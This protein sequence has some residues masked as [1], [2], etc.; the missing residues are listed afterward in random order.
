MRRGPRWDEHVSD[1][2]EAYERLVAEPEEDAMG[3]KIRCKFKCVSVTKREGWGSNPI[4][5]DAAF[6]VV[7]G[8]SPENNS[9][10]AATP[11][12]EIKV[13]TVAADRFE[14]GK[15]YFVDFSPA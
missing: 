6:Q 2:I 7:H 3:E 12:G 13:G 1:A 4:I 9:F 5:H 8:G 15:E 14:V 10:F 11:S